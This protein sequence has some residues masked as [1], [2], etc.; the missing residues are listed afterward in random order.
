MTKMCKNKMPRMLRSLTGVVLR[1]TAVVLGLLGVEVTGGRTF[2]DSES[3]SSGT[4]R[5][6]CFLTTGDIS[7][8]ISFWF[9]AKIFVRSDKL[10]FLVVA[11]NSSKFSVGT[12][13]DL[14]APATG[15]SF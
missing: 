12:F 9:S 4:V 6:V 3:E 10:S 1:L 14:L 8:S 11:F 5:V 13:G 15:F 2:S 7:F